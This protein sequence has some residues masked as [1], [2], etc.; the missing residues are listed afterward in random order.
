MLV[1][2]TKDPIILRKSPTRVRYYMDS[3]ILAIGVRMQ[4]GALA[5]E[6]NPCRNGP[7]VVRHKFGKALSVPTERRRQKTADVVLLLVLPRGNIS[8]VGVQFAG[9][10]PRGREMRESNNLL[11]LGV[12]IPHE[13]PQIGNDRPETEDHTRAHGQRR[14]TRKQNDAERSLLAYIVMYA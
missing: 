1:V 10:G 13:C 6:A 7:F 5:Q 14:A 3:D 9:P 11:R 12:G 4:L 8:L 2:H